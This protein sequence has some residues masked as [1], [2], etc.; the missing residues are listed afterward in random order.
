MMSHF[1]RGSRRL[2]ALCALLF[3]TVQG[4]LALG[5]AKS[6]GKSAAA[7]SGRYG[8]SDAIPQP[9][10]SMQAVASAQGAAAINHVVFMLQENHSFDSYFGMLNP[11][12]QRMATTLVTT[13]IYT[14]VDGIDDKLYLT[15]RMMKA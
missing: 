13:D 11:Y 2:I 7:D 15:T 12:R 10:T 9:S 4:L 5:T 3:G 6:M 14:S 1:H 8:E